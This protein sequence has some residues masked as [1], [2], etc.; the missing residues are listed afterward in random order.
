MDAIMI[1]LVAVLLANADGR[2]GVFLA[3]LAAL[4]NDA[5]TVMAI[6]FAGFAANALVAASIGTLAN[7]T[8]GQ[9]AIVL[10]VAVA[11]VAAAVALLW[12]RR[13]H[14]DARLVAAPMPLLALRML[15]AQIGDRGSFL[16]AALAATS[17]AG[18][19]AAAGGTIGWL[20]A[21][22]PFLALGPALADRPPARLLRWASAAILLLWGLRS[23]LGAFGLFA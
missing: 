15:A 11:L 7:R 17:G 19:W 18:L 4:R 1:T 3:R 20:L 8:I 10:I 22:L 5:R 9:G 14:D 21:L 13:P 16:I 6:A 2:S 23:A 12:S